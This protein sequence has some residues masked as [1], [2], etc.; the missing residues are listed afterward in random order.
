MPDLAPVGIA[1]FTGCD[2]A[3]MPAILAGS[4]DAFL[5]P[6]RWIGCFPEALQLAFPQVHCPWRIECVENTA[7]PRSA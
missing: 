5:K 7:H 1:T 4:V 6:P 2:C 3:N